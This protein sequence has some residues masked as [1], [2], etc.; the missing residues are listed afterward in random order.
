MNIQ[1]QV[2]RRAL[3]VSYAHPRLRMALREGWGLLQ[4]TTRRTGLPPLLEPAEFADLRRLAATAA[5]PERDSPTVLALSTRG[6]STHLA[7]EA[8]VG[9]ALLQHG[10]L[11]IFMTCG[12]RLQ[13]CDVAPVH[14]APPMP[15]HSCRSYA[16]G[17]LGAAGFDTIEVRDLVSVRQAALLARP[18]V[19]ELAT[20]DACREYV[21]A[22]YPVGDWVRTSVLWFL[23][24][25]RLL[26]DAETVATYRKFLVSGSVL[27]QAFAAILDTTRPRAV[28]LLNGAFFPERILA[29]LASERE[30]PVTRYERGFLIGTVLVSRWRRGADDLDPGDDAWRAVEDRPLTP[31]EEATVDGYLRERMHGGGTFDNFWRDRMDDVTQ[32]RRGLGL[33]EGRHLVAVFT[34]ILWDSAIQGKDRAFASMPD[35]LTATIAWARLRPDIDLVIRL[36]PAEVRLANHPTRER[37]ADHI[38]TTV[39]DLPRNVRVVPSKSTVSSYALLAAA[40][41]CLTY[42]STVGLE[43][44]CQGM[45]VVNAGITHYGDRGFTD[46]PATPTRYWETVDRLIATGLSPAER[47]RRSRV[48][49]RYAYLFFFR[50]HQFLEVIDEVGRSRPRI[51]VDSASALRSGAVPALDRIVENIMS[52]TGAV[53]TPASALPTAF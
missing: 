43:A 50:F 17:A 36:H 10:V 30:I 27:R 51:N 44:A 40:R 12:G 25:G 45:P 49:R 46:D 8:V 26:D 34:N 11:P 3:E 6:W 38:E 18:A 7:I 29:E 4:Q 48:A 21:E 23:S 42:T 5:R 32:I 53:I 15:C 33:G 52:G 20:V 19:Q 39:P 37:M 2:L 35:W 1:D 24:R 9:H 47:E 22:G 16:T 13:V 28:F 31:T 41:V 14:A